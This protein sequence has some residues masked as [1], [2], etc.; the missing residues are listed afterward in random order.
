M[1]VITWNCNMGFRKKA[2]YILEHHPDILVVPECENLDK[3]HFADGVPLPSDSIWQGKNPHKGLGVFAYNGY[4]LELLDCHNPDFKNILPIAV[5]GGAV[6]FMLFAIWANNPEDK[7]GPYITQIWKALKHYDHLLAETKTL[8]VGDF[9]SNTIWDKPK[10]EG[11]H[12]TLVAKLE[13][14]HILSTYHH[15]FNQ[16]QG[17]EAHPTFYFYRHEDKPYHLDY[18]F[19]SADFIQK[20]TSVEVGAYTNWTMHSDHKPLMVEFDFG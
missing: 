8:L 10:R 11:N 16:E 9:N 3:L 17:K 5:T 14:K 20:M 13:A 2:G 12:S 19:A 6:D 18:C 15:F 7:D 4:K 1:K